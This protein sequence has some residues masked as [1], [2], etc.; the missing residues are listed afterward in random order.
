MK[1]GKKSVL[2]NKYPHLIVKSL[3]TKKYLSDMP[4]CDVEIPILQV[5][6]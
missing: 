2:I 4:N 1:S 3:L 5:K 6:V